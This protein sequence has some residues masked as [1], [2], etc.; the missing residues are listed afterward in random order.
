M[1]LI[2]DLRTFKEYRNLVYS[3]GVRRVLVLCNSEVRV[4]YLRNERESYP[5]LTGKIHFYTEEDFA[6]MMANTSSGC[7]GLDLSDL[8]P[9]KKLAFLADNRNN[10]RERFKDQYN[11]ICL[12][13]YSYIP[14]IVNVIMEKGLMEP[15][16]EY[17][18]EHNHYTDTFE[19]S[20]FDRNRELACRGNDPRVLEPIVQLL[21]GNG[22]L[23]KGV[24]A[25][26]MMICHLDSLNDRVTIDG[27]FKAY[28]I[29]KERLGNDKDILEY[30]ND[31]KEAAYAFC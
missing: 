15:E 12:D 22:D 23:K 3:L 21:N 10:F 8:S 7:F 29:L 16:G 25:I 11:V 1:K 24:E 14:E 2:T 5:D 18:L 4:D 27:L 9:A 31:L 26:E 17:S 20:V 6:E 30:I 13:D 19:Y 28:A